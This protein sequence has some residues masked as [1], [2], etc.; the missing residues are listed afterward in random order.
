MQTITVE[1]LKAKLDAGEQIHLVDVREPHEHAEF[2]IG[3]ILLP[4]GKVQTMQVDEIEDLKDETIYVYCRSG[5]RS[6]QACLILGT[7]GFQN[8]V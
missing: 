1:D 8:L 5:N 6:G 3:G 2:N 4:L 7:M